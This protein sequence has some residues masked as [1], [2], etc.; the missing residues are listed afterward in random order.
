LQYFSKEEIWEL[1]ETTNKFK[2]STISEESNILKGKSITLLFQKPST[3]TRVSF[4]VAINQLGGNSLYFG[5]KESQLGRGETIADTTR[6]LNK[7]IDCI[8]ARVNKHAVI[9]DMSKNADVP[10][11]NALSDIYHPCQTLTDLFTLWKVQGFL[12]GLKIAYIGDGNNVCN[13]LLIGCSK[14]GIN[15]SVASPDGYEP[16]RK[17]I[18][19][20]KQNSKIS[21]SKIN[22]INNPFDAVKNANVIY[23]DTF[24]SMGMENENKT[25]LRAF[26]PKYQVTLD[27]FNNAIEDA[28]FMHCLPVHRNEE[29]TDEVID[30]PRSIVWEQAE[31]RLHT[32]KAILTKTIQ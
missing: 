25:R 20:A 11:I 13:S 29:V 3:R 17:A 31:N 8:I 24:V 2:N 32:A 19:Y 30:G 12:K 23:T 21:G 26:L 16:F 6:V 28:V 5:W 7:Y 14:M 15:I 1:L 10:I 22:I 4:E 9:D 27:L 18:E